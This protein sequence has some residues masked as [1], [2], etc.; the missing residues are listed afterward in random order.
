MAKSSVSTVTVWQTWKDDHTITH[1]IVNS[2]ENLRFG[3]EDYF[4][5]LY[6]GYFIKEIENIFSCVPIR[7]RNTRG[8]LGELEIAQ[9][10]HLC[11][12]NCLETWKMFSIKCMKLV[13]YI[14]ECGSLV[15]DI[16]V[17]EPL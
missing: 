4:H 7:Y 15:S 14:G 12:Y 2:M 11:F 1:A 6:S 8:S 10:L 13:T 17:L 3:K 5:V 16:G 9:K